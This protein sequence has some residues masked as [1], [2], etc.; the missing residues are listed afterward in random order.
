MA[1]TRPSTSA[2]AAK[3][4]GAPP[5]PMLVGKRTSTQGAEPP[6]E[7]YAK[8]GLGFWKD[9]FGPGRLVPWPSFVKALQDFLRRTNP[10]QLQGFVA[11]EQALRFLIDRGESSVARNVVALE[12]WAVFLHRF[13]PV[14]CCV[15]KAT[16]SFFTPEGQMVPW[17]HGNVSRQ[18]AKDL[19]MGEAGGKPGS[20]LVRFSETNP[21]NFTLTYMD[22][23]E[24]L[25]QQEQQRQ[26]LLPQ[27]QQDAGAGALAAPC[28]LPLQPKYKNVLLYNRGALGFALEPAGPEDDCYATVRELIECRQGW[29][30]PCLSA[31]STRF[32]EE[33]QRGES[34][35]GSL[36]SLSSEKSRFRRNGSNSSLDSAA[37]AAAAEAQLHRRRLS[38]SSSNNL[39]RL[40][41][42][43]RLSSASNGALSDAGSDGNE[44]DESGHGSLL[45]SPIDSPEGETLYM[46][47][48]DLDGEEGA[49][50]DGR[51]S[52]HHH[53]H[54]HHSSGDEEEDDDI[55]HASHG[56]S[57]RRGRRQSDEEE[58]D[59]DDD[60]EDEDEEEDAHEPSEEEMRQRL[61]LL[62]TMSSVSSLEEAVELLNRAMMSTASGKYDEALKMLD[63]VLG[64]A[65]AE[66][67]S[68]E[69]ADM[70]ARAAK[71]KGTVLQEMGL[72][73]EASVWY[74]LCVRA[75][76]RVLQQV[77][78]DQ[79]MGPYFAPL[80][81]VHNQL[82]QFYLSVRA[83]NLVLEHFE[84]LLA[85]TDDAA[86]RR[87]ILREFERLSLEH[88]FWQ[89]VTPGMLEQELEHGKRWYKEKNLEEAGLQFRRVIQLA[90]LASFSSATDRLLEARALGNYATVLKELHKSDDAILSYRFCCRILHDLDEK[91][92]ERRML[93]GLSLCYMEAARYEDAKEVCQR[94]LALTEREDNA[95][96]IRSRIE[97]I[98]G[99]LRAED[100]GGEEE[101]EEGGQGGDAGAKDGD[102]SSSSSSSSSSST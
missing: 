13:G 21:R 93:N 9:H 22:E 4:P 55:S 23:A 15:G 78:A 7:D 86:E 94:L 60:D 77:P 18:R 54:H 67:A 70:Q 79:D 37:A 97:E 33:V 81:Y 75:G 12:E 101:E 66:H 71:V 102:D 96:L 17:F 44:V 48:S 29:S 84:Q 82:A 74:E 65:G 3:P 59:E 85:L 26:Q 69:E 11:L 2:A 36:P 46:H 87:L 38:G 91:Q 28:P 76:H 34:L 32:S 62:H 35:A 63:D 8:S 52:H 45:D 80:R 30:V 95:T 41:S 99:H 50:E 19:L 20:F 100:A 27:Q 42:S 40:N 98:V 64:A 61:R 89:D 16:R 47:G 43:L 92:M 73:K 49:D 53:H 58:E 88:D 14:E 72:M 56:S 25:L 51:H 68:L 5:V 83:F 24:L 1:T 90:R 31:L 10:Q 57:P 6:L 39:R